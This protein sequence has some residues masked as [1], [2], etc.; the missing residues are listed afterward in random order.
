MDAHAAKGHGDWNS[1]IDV[2]SHAPKTRHKANPLRMDFWIS[3]M[4]KRFFD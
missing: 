1:S 3:F 2:S 4:V